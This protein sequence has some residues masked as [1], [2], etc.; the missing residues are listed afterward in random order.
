[1]I[2]S[3]HQPENKALKGIIFL[4]TGCFNFLTLIH[5]VIIGIKGERADDLEVSFFHYLITIGCV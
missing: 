2:P 3:M 4:A 5:S 1:M